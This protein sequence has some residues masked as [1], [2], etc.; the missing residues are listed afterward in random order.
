MTLRIY[1]VVLVISLI[2]S[3]TVYGNDKTDTKAPG[4]YDLIPGTVYPL[5]IPPRQ[6]D[7]KLFP[8][9][10]FQEMLPKGSIIKFTNEYTISVQKETGIIH[11][12]TV[13]RPVELV[14]CFTER[15]RLITDI[16]SIGFSRTSKVGFLPNEV[17][18]KGDTI[19]KMACKTTRVE[20][21]Q[22]PS[23]FLE[24]ELLNREQHR[25]Y[26]AAMRSLNY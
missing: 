17:A 1:R 22:E 13:K 20:G 5:D 19:V 25:K 6:L 11:H 4:F 24:I 9:A 10:Y 15:S 14:N 21:G 2:F 23:P 8:Y 12:V 7:R 18:F 16:E 26:E 3:G